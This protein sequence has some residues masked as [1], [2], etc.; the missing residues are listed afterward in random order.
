MM[1][2]AEDIKHKLLSSWSLSQVAWVTIGTGTRLMKGFSTGKL[3]AD[4]PM[5]RKDIQGWARKICRAFDIRVT[6]KGDDID[7]GPGILVG[8]HMSY[9]DIPVL[10][11]IEPMSFVAKAEVKSIPLIGPSAEGFGVIFIERS[12]EESRKNTSDALSNAITKKNRRV[13]VFPEG[14]TSLKGLPWRAGVFKRA[15]ENKIPMQA[16]CICYNPAAIAAFQIDSMLDHALSLPK[17]GPIEVVVTFG[18]RFMVTDFLK[19]FEKWEKWSKE[20]LSAELARQG[21]V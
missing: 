15:Q 4:S 5:A 12:S 19:D 8:N 13:V 16:M 1:P 2:S 3:T 10:L 14:T 11:S 7:T 18:P 21:V 17:A 6:L 9:L 20:T